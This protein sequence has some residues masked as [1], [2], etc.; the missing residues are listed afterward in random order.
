[1]GFT[2]KENLHKESKDQQ[3]MLKF[4]KKK[5]MEALE[6]YEAVN[7]YYGQCYCLDM[8]LKLKHIPREFTSAEIKALEKK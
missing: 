6:L 8:L 2:L 7:H 1:M 5:F 4:A 3:S